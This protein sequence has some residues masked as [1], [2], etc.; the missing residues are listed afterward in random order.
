M[1]HCV[2]E[3]M[4]A[5]QQLANGRI[6]SNGIRIIPGAY[7]YRSAASAYEVSACFISERTPE[8]LQE[9]LP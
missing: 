6:T 3:I 7:C 1:D 9:R 4:N 2:Y 5:E 8:K